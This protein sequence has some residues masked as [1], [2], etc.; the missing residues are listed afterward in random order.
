[1]FTQ[2]ANDLAESRLWA[3]IHYQT[4]IDVG[5][6]QGRN[7]AQEVIKVANADGSNSAGAA[8]AN[9]EICQAD[10]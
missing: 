3:G 1:V 6:A 5:L 7:V 4:D 9:P 2:E 8:A 10:R